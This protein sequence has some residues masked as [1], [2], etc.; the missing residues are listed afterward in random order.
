MS[1]GYSVILGVVGTAL[2]SILFYQLIKTAG[3]VFASMVTYGIPFVALGWGLLDGEIVGWLQIL[4]LAVILGGVYL[5]N[6]NSSK[7]KR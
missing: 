5:A 1:V 6:S 7:I 3:S 4:G 2:A